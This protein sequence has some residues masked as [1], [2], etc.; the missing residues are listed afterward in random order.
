MFESNPHVALNSSRRLWIALAAL[1]TML[2][3]AVSAE[4]ATYYIG[5]FSGST[6]ADD[7]GCGTGKGAA[8]NA[9]PCK[10]IGYW[11]KNRRQSLVAND[12]VRIA[13]GT[14]TDN[15]PAANTGHH[16]ILLDR[17]ARNVTY[18]GRTA[19]D[20]VLDDHSSVVLDLAGVSQVSFTGNNPCQA[21]AI[22]ARHSCTTDLYSGVVV[23]DMQLKNAPQGGIE[24]CGTSSNVSSGITLDRIRI[25]KVASNGTGMVGRFDNSYLNTDLDCRNG[26]RTVKNLTILDSEF[27]HNK[28]FPGGLLLA[29]VDG[30]TISRTSVHDICDL[31]DCNT[32]L[33]DW[34]Q[35]GC[36]DRDGIGMAGAI[37]VTISDST[38]T[39]VGEDG[40]DIGGHPFGKSH[41]VVVERTSSYDNPGGNFKT[42]GG[43][44]VTLR[45]N[46]SWG[47]GTGYEMYHC[48]HHVKLQNNTF[49]TNGVAVQVFNYLTQSEFTNNIFMSQTGGYVVF[50]DKASTNTTNVW[51]NNVVVNMNS[52][53]NGMG[54]FDGGALE[55]P[56]CDGNN[57]SH[58][59]GDCSLGFEPPPIPCPLGTTASPAMLPDNASGVSTL[60]SKGAAGQW[61]G[62]NSGAGDKW[63]TAPAFV[64]A[65]TLNAANLHLGPSDTVAKDAGMSLSP[66][67][68]D[69]DRE[70]RSG[71]WDIG[72]DE[73]QGA[74]GVPSAPSLISVDPVP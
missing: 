36:D 21:R 69:F 9:H 58:P 39:H 46:Y 33:N 52:S 48:S 55:D 28:G 19:A 43:R 24:M 64:N 67:I 20:G 7:A 23:R 2:S 56:K 10:T 62:N 32:C 73:F 68:D 57:H 3:S 45:N 50:V 70:G 8:P 51:R 38:V 40:I 34:S 35:S 18:E 54:E 49:W 44:Y 37:N 5:Q 30:V 14:Y 12:V 27:D 26:G 31:P 74:A 22:T 65:G 15:G 4:S 16:C 41:H 6:P 59:G 60:Q 72:A 66:A 25:T 29:C 42:S 61:F 1:V 17:Y 47:K 71:A 63:G 11:N 13:P 53:G